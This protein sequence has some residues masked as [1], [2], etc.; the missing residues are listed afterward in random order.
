MPFPAVRSCDAL[1]VKVAT[2]IKARSS[3]RTYERGY[4]A[5]GYRTTL[6]DAATG[7]AMET[8]EAMDAFGNVTRTTHGNGV[9]ETRAFDAKTGRP[10][11][12]DALSSGGT[13]IR[14]DAYAWRSDGLL[15]SRASHVGGNSAKLEEFDRDPLGRLTKAATKLGGV[16]KRT[17]SYTY[18]AK[19]N[20]KTRTGSVDADIDVSAYGYDAAKPHRLAGA[21]IEGK[22]Y[23]FA[24][25]ADGNIEKYDC[26]PA[27][28]EDRFVEWS[29]RNLPVRIT[30]GSGKADKTPTARDEFAYGPDGARYRRQATFADGD[31][32]RTERTY[33]VDKSTILRN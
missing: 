30:V 10:T 4:N 2:A 6:T 23:K 22:T 26:V 21:T 33:H 32:Q 18:D 5:H 24:H 12:I 19:G 7:K 28:C 31:S 25:D 13:K 8:R 16:A 1:V 14:D 9:A 17:L 11:D 20:L 27:G 3:A 29:G 15:A